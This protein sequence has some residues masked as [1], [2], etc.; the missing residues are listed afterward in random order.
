MKLKL[1][2]YNK[3]LAFRLKIKL[4]TVF[5][6]ISVVVINSRR[7]FTVFNS[8]DRKTSSQKA[9]AIKLQKN[10]KIRINHC[11]CLNFYRVAIKFECSDP[12]MEQ[13]Q[14]ITMQINI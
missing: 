9:S 3:D 5:K 4:V 6:N 11:L 12:N 10:P 1:G 8:V 2:V 7:I 14:K 13:L